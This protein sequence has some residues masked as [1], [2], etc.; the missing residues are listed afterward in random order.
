MNDKTIL[1]RHFSRT[2]ESNAG[3]GDETDAEGTDNLGSFGWLRGMRE[4]AVMLELRKK[5]GNVLAVGY[6]WLE[7]AEFNPSEGITLSV[8]GQKI[9][10]K[11]R[12]LNAEV[13]SAVRLFEGIT[14]HRVPWVQEAGEP[15][16]M[17]SDEKTTLIE[18]V[19]W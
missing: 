16:S 17:E 13:R 1:Q 15:E 14:R 12:N 3:G 6:G 9:R 11:G 19:E 2:N 7:K 5:D 4:R 10:I 18:D 8:A